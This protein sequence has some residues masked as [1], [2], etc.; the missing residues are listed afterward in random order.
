MQVDLTDKLESYS[1]EMRGWCLPLFT[2]L[3]YEMAA[4]ELKKETTYFASVNGY[5][6][7]VKYCVIP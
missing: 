3:N 5:V 6:N 7:Y 1:Y 2:P 4:H